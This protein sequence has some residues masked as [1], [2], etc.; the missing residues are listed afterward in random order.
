VYAVFTDK[1]DVVGRLERL[2][3]AKGYR[4]S[5][6]RAKV[7]PRDRERWIEQ[8]APDSDVIISHPQLVQ[9]GLDFFSQRPGGYNVPSIVFYETGYN[10]FTLMQASRRAWRIGQKRECR[11]FYLY[12]ADSIQSRAMALMG[13][14]AVAANAINGRFSSEGLTAMAGEAETLE[15]ALAR[16]LA[17]R[18]RSASPV[19]AW[20]K[21]T[22]QLTGQV[23]VTQETVDAMRARLAARQARRQQTLFNNA[24]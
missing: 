17:E 12:H 10:L 7:S 14:K 23:E 21:L 1:R 8:N 2:I 5:V 24:S 9:T 20:K 15:M 19:L 11:T 6:L 16:E 18:A 13:S 3:R 22:T 4:V